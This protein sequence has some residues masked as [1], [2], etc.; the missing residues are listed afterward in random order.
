MLASLNTHYSIDVV[1][2]ESVA[3]FYRALGLTQVVGMAQRNYARQALR[4][5]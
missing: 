2:D 3:G 1:C 5:S 4:L